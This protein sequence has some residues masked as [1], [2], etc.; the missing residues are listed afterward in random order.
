MD[1]VAVLCLE[2]WLLLA[3]MLKRPENAS[4]TR[5]RTLTPLAAVRLSLEQKPHS[6]TV[7]PQQEDTTE[8]AAVNHFL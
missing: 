6:M 5:V 8:T 4:P 7:F 3:G 2:K 1:I